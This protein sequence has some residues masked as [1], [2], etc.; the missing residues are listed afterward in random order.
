MFGDVEGILGRGRAS[1]H[2]SL[3]LGLSHYPT[4]KLAL[5]A[6]MT[7]ISPLS[8]DSYIVG[9]LDFLGLAFSP[10]VLIPSFSHKSPDFSENS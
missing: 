5:R 7:G 4:I 2:T 3:G 1:S 6:E 10:T 9:G 8:R